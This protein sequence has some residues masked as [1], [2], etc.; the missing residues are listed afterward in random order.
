MRQSSPRL[1]P[2]AG[3][4]EVLGPE[5][6]QMLGRRGQEE[7]SKRLEVPSAEFASARQGEDLETLWIGECA[8]KVGRAGC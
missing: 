8:Q 7:R 5:S 1:G 3:A 6:G 2:P 4:D